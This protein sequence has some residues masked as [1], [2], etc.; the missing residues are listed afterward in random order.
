MN[1][2]S[3][4]AIR[5]REAMDARH[6]RASE[7]SQI[8]GIGKSAISQ[9]LSDKVTP[10]QDKIYALAQALD[11]NEAWLMG[12]DVPM[13]ARAAQDNTD[14]NIQEV[15]WNASHS[16]R[17]NQRDSEVI[18]NAAADGLSEVYF[19]FARDAQANGI[20]PDDILDAIEILKT[21]KNK[22]NQ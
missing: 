7:I 19:S 2:V 1:K 12:L 22:R 11:V 16:T 3:T 4:T 9:Y 15:I 20:D 6:M 5:L 10:K 8:T 17:S 18:A 13:N 21:I 14:M